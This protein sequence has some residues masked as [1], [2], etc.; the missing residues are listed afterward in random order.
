MVAF[1]LGGG[2]L[3]TKSVHTK[4]YSRFLEL[5]I[6]ARQDAGITQEEVADRLNRP[7]SFV[8]KYENAE[9]RVDVIEFLDIAQAIGFDPVDFV[10]KIQRHR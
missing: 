2:E 4:D 1:Q 10:R 9:R 6:K 3:V 5:L 8:S 7:Q